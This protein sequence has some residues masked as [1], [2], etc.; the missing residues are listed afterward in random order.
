[1]RLAHRTLR[2]HLLGLQTILELQTTLDTQRVHSVMLFHTL[3]EH[4]EAYVMG[5]HQSSG[6]MDYFDM[7]VK[8]ILYIL[9]F[10]LYHNFQLFHNLF[11][12]NYLTIYVNKYTAGVP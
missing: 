12:F 5:L 6:M 4:V 2:I 10:V 11:L 7:Q 9:Y 1:M 3:A 8:L